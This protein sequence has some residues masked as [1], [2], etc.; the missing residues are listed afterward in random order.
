VTV[1]HSVVG[2]ALLVSSFAAEPFR[3]PTRQDQRVNATG[4]AVQAFQKQL[5]EY[6]KLHHEA[7]SKVP[8]LN[9]TSD[10]H[11]LA[12]REAALAAAIQQL[13]ADARPGDIFVAEFQ[14]V[15]IEAVRNDFSTRT[16]VDRKAMVQEL[17][18]SM[19]LSVNMV[20][21]SSLPLATFPAKLLR[22]LPDLPPEL[23]YRIVGRDLILRDVKA[24]LVI[25]FVRNVVPTIP[26]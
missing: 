26:S 19:K 5:A 11:K 15:L 9:E 2:L 8:S 7:D 13:R 16:A 6:V 24:N 3:H 25:D 10:P 12:S 1:M 21:P 20:Y 23:E 22:A 14:P 17:P 4:A 18:K